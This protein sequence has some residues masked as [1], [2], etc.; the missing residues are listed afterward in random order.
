MRIIGGRHRG[1]PLAAPP[2]RTARPTSDRTR[3]TLFNILAHGLGHA[4]EGATMVDAFAGSGAVAFEALSRGARH[5]YLIDDNAASID[6]IR[7]N[8][9]ALGETGRVTILRCDARRPPAAPGPCDLAFL[10]PPYGS[11]LAAPALSAL[12]ARGWL[13][14]DALCVVEIGSDEP[15]APPQG[16]RIEKERPSGAARLVFLS[17]S[18]QAGSGED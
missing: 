3:E 7:K 8:A 10:D 4:L 11:G 15:F 2:G 9:A 6:S 1:R 13:A 5:A 16:F 17:H 14:E 12:S 18:R